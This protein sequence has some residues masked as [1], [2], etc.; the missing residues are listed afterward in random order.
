[1]TAV[2]VLDDQTAA[3]IREAMTAARSG[4]LSEAV[5][6]GQR[7]LA[8]GGNPAALN[9][10]LGTFH[11]QLGDLQTGIRH[12]RLAHRDRPFDPVVAGN[13]AT[14]LAQQ[15]DHAS[16]LEVLTEELAGKDPTLHL[17]RMRAFLAQETGNFAVS[18]PAYESIVATAPDDWEAWNNLGNARRLA[19]DADGSVEALQRAVA[20]NSSSPPVRLNYAMALAS[21]GRV[22]EAEQ[23]L[24][25]MAEDFPRDTK[26]LQELHAIF[27]ELGREEDAL[28]AIEAASARSP[29]DMELLLG[30]ASQRLNLLHTDR[31]EETY[32]RA[33]A[34][35]PSHDLA[36]LG[37]AVVFELT[38]RTDELSKLSAE[39]AKRG[40]GKDVLNFI[41]AMV[42]RREKKFAEGLASLARVPVELESTRRY[43]LLGQLEEGAGN[44]EEAFA[45]FSRMNALQAADLTKPEQRAAA[46]RNSIRTQTETL[47]PAW[48]KEWRKEGRRDKR[49]TPAFL[50]GFPRSG[51]TLLDT[52]LMGHP[53]AEV[54]EEEPTLLGA[55]R[56]LQP[57]DDLPT[58][59]D[60]QIGKAREEYFRIASEHSPLQP[61]KLLI[62]KNPLSMNLVP[63]IRRLF[64]DARIVLALRHPCDVI[65]SCYASNFKVNDGMSSFLH[66][67]TA[68]ELYDL[69]FKYFEKAQK[70]FDP[71]THVIKYEN[72]VADRES[73]LRA[74]LAFLGLEW[75]EQV[76]DH[77]ATA[78]ARGRIKT[79]S[80]AQVAQP[81]YTQA[82]GRWANFRKHLEPVLPVLEPWVARFGYSL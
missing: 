73:E 17:Q 71:P 56:R 35:E 59:S 50:V 40:V 20:L 55:A 75:S 22:D 2:S 74:L 51:T 53:D 77:Q 16:A 47:K 78:K 19:G 42:H 15:G 65:L 27:K 43:H 49:P 82:A 5:S 32:R 11:C 70:L 57:F 61:G 79:A 44:F 6:V 63:I 72:V 54:L 3:A 26:P 29:D 36:N 64:P 38:N 39:V 37:L 7:A 28:E 31:A 80:Y 41:Q 76:L 9:A 34:L 67:D 68:A 30:V 4:R 23:G 48:V 14:A 45:A 13:L 81:I 1:M 21:A 33:I 24:R 18:I 12:L 8:D 62:D 58:A 52:M 66:L 60:E 10:M 25:Q 69:S 46:Y